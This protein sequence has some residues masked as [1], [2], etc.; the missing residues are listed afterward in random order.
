MGAILL[1]GVDDRR[2][3]RSSPPGRWSSRACRCR[4][5]RWSWAARRKVQAPADRRRGRP[6]SRCTPTATSRYRLDYMATGSRLTACHRTRPAARH[7][8]L[9]ARRRPPARVRHRRRPRR[10]RAVRVRAARDAGVR[11]HRDAARQVRRRRQQAHFQDPEARRARGER[12]GGPGA[13]LRPDGAARARRRAVPERAA[14]VLQALS[15][16]A[17]L[18]RRSA[19]AR[20]VPRVLPVRHR[21]DRL[22]VA[23]RRGELLAAVSDVLTT[24]RLRRLRHPAE[25]PARADGA[26]RRRRRAGARSTATRSSR[27]TSWTRSAPTASPTE[28]AARGIDAAVAAAC[29]ELFDASRTEPPSRRLGAAR[30][31]RCRTTRIGAVAN[32]RDDRRAGR[33]RRRPPAR[34]RVDPSLARGLSYYTGAIMEIAVPDLA[35]SLGGGGRYDNLIGMFLG[36]EV[37]ACGFSLGLERIIVVMTEREMFPATVVARRRRRDGRRFWNERSAR[38]RAGAGRASCGAA[39][40]ASTSIPRPTSSDKQFKYASSRSVPFVAIRRRRRARA[41]QGGGQGSAD[42]AAG[43]PS[44]AAERRARARLR[45]ERVRIEQ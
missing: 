16:S 36:R 42:A 33:R 15:D 9:P 43:A 30:A 23:G 21:R 45:T 44:R 22:D 25:P 10:L 17:G 24:A 8:R 38:R 5:A 18:A 20:A 1:N 29:L 7:A 32:L 37:P 28:L 3:T 40:C 14:E 12:R 26:A 27:S 13:A 19:G 4:R 11:E 34:I 41:G 35:G 2:R 6:R 39:G 31:A